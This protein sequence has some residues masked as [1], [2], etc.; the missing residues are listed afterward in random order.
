MFCFYSSE[1]RLVLLVYVIFIYR[2][3]LYKQCS[4]HWLC[5]L[6]FTWLKCSNLMQECPW[7]Y[8]SR[9]GLMAEKEDLLSVETITLLKVMEPHVQLSMEIGT[10]AFIYGRQWRQKLMGIHPFFHSLF[11]KSS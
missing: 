8:W 5:T 1:N 7:I 11:F 10:S 4:V 9:T 3:S 6:F 2:A